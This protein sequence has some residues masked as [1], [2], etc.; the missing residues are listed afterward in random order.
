MLILEEILEHWGSSRDWKK[1][2]VVPMSCQS[3]KKK[4]LHSNYGP[5]ILISIQCKNMERLIRDAISK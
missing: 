5:V 4:R 3:F 2:N 1:A